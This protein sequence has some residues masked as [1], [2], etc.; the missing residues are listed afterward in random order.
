MVS[1]QRA[2][3]SGVPLYYQKHSMKWEVKEYTPGRYSFNSCPRQLWLEVMTPQAAGEMDWVKSC[4]QGWWLSTDSPGW[5]SWIWSSSNLSCKIIHIQFTN[6]K[7]K[8]SEDSH[9]NATP[10]KLCYLHLIKCTSV[11]QNML[12]F[13]C[14]MYV[15]NIHCLNSK[16]L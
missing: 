14:S 12:S 6:K 5:L 4:P 3:S 16:E 8:R 10:E 7:S 9:S 15:G 11:T 2:F 13:I 1:H